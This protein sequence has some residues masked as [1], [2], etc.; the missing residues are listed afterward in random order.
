MNIQVSWDNDEKTIIRF[1]HSKGCTWDD[2]AEANRI[3]E[4]MQAEVKHPIH[5][6]ANF[7]DGAFPPLGALDKFR[8]A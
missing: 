5:I 3:V 2:F 1:G 8:H 4:K 7:E 6:I